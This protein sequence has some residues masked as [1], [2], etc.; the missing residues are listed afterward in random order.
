[1][2]AEQLPKYDTPPVA[3]VVFGTQFESIAGLTPEYVGRLWTEVFKEAFGQRQ[4]EP[5]LTPQ[6][7]FFGDQVR[8]VSDVTKDPASRRSWFI[9]DNGSLVQVQKD[10][11]L[12]NWRPDNTKHRY[13]G[14]EPIR[15]AYLSALEAF[16]AFLDKYELGALAHRQYELTYVSHIQRDERWKHT[17]DIGVVFPDIT[18]RREPRALKDLEGMALSL[19][20][21]KP[22]DGMRL[23][24]SLGHATHRDTGDQI[25]R[26]DLTARGMPHTP[27]HDD[28]LA[29]FDRAHEWIVS[30]VADLTSETILRDNWS[31][32]ETHD[33]RSS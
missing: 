16:E 6:T 25:L 10:R 11:L 28:M 18:W 2:S 7:E 22:E 29:W 31:R 17:A 1:M 9:D 4:E 24:V 21:A 15:A 30:G 12:Y 32:K 27:S 14:Y 26:L 19:S 3:E 8:S 20:F 23:Y 33:A 5:L 13:P